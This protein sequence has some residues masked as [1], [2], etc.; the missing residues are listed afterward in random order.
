MDS[1]YSDKLYNVYKILNQC[2]LTVSEIKKSGTKKIEV[3]C[4]METTYI[5]L[6]C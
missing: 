5:I 1:E 2:M 4:I 3:E 6:I